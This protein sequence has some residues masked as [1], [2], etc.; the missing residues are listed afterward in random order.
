MAGLIAAIVT[1]AGWLANHR[2]TARSER[3]RRQYETSLAHVDKQLEQLYGPLVFLV[4]EGRA[5]WKEFCDSLGR[6]IVFEG[7][8]R[9]NEEEM[10]LWLFWVDNEF[11]PRNA[12]IQTLLSSNAH[13]IEGNQMPQ[14]CLMF[15][16]HYTSW[17][18]THLRW[19]EERVSYRWRARVNWPSQF[20]FEVIDTF[21]R[22]KNQQ[23]RLAGQLRRIEG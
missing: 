16:E 3:E 17:R 23:A 20:E 14:S 2:L 22:L 11:M 1:A 5:A 7:E 18:L 15:I 10:R 13:L 8:G 9:L 12:A 6:G 19:K 21:K 4:Q